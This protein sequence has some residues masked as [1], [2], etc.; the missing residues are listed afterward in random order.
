VQGQPRRRHGCAWLLYA[1][2]D[3]KF[4]LCS[5]VERAAEL[6]PRSRAAEFT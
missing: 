5:W 3:N 6:Y 4:S 2:G 1:S